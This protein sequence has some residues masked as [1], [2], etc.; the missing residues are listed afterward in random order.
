MPGTKVLLILTLLMCYHVGA[1]NKIIFQVP[2]HYMHYVDTL[3]NRLVDSNKNKNAIGNAIVNLFEEKG[4]AFGK[5]SIAQNSDTTLVHLNPGQIY[6]FGSIKYIGSTKTKKRIL[7]KIID[8][9]PYST[10]NKQ[11]LLDAEA[12]IIITPFLSLNS[13]I[14]LARHPYK[15]IIYPIIDLKDTKGSSIDGFMGY[16]EQN[17]LTGSATILLANIM[18]TG[19]QLD[20]NFN[21]SHNESYL[22]L[23]FIEPWLFNYNLNLSLDFESNF[24]KH[25]E[26]YWQTG[27]TIQQVWSKTVQLAYGL[28]LKT[29][30]RD[31]ISIRQWQQDLKA[32]YQS[33]HYLL[34]EPEQKV[35]AQFSFHNN[36]EFSTVLTHVEY[37][38]V[39]NVT[40][41]FILLN[42]SNAGRL[43]N[44]NQF[45]ISDLF[46]IGG[47]RSIRGMEFQQY[48]ATDYFYNKL[49]FGYYFK[50]RLYLHLLCDPY[51]IRVPTFPDKWE[52]GV[53]YGIGLRSYLNN[54]TISVEIANSTQREF[55]SF[56]LH[57]QLKSLF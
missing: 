26:S 32:E 52:E 24:I 10:F 53:G 6:Y 27:F 17:S 43:W 51:L 34:A 19:R 50:P 57:L 54:T 39:L 3:N 12:N 29:L 46:Q 56:L 30:L 22:Q 31:S 45:F 36:E 11:S 42:A 48:R 18:G 37:S 28:S 35:S 1:E 38:Q 47:H 55:S 16:S 5:Y 8:I 15:H 20:F 14:N 2:N 41:H 21:S 4:H 33:K 44:R 25:S 49:S 7:Q 9:K 13:K 23:H 40:R